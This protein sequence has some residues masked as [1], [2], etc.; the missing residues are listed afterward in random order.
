MGAGRNCRKWQSPAFPE[1]VERMLE[2]LDTEIITWNGTANGEEPVYRAVYKGMPIALFIL[3]VGAPV[4]VGML[5][6]VFQ[7]GVQKVVI[8]GPAAFWQRLGLLVIIPDRVLR[9]EGTSYHY[10]PPSDEIEV[11]QKSMKMFTELLDELHVKYTVGKTWTTDSFYRETPEKVK[12]RKAAGC[13]CVDMECSANAA[14]CDFRGKKLLQFFYAADNLDA[15]E[16]DS[17][18]LANHS[19]MEDKNRI[20]AIALEAAVRM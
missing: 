16:W 5:E 1:N 15:E 17:R 7:M 19:R 12:R 13:I 10:A 3:D 4:S 9:D 14:V 8:F 20:A 6:E 18:S 2:D 11:N